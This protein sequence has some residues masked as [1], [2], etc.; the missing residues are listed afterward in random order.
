M[1]SPLLASLLAQTS[2][3][4][5]E[6]R[7][8]RVVDEQAA[9]WN[10]SFA[11]GVVW[12]P[13]AS[14]AMAAGG[15]ED[16]RSG[17]KASTSSLYP[18]GSATKLYTAIICLQLAERGLLDL[19]VPLARYVD[20]FLARTNGTSL[21][22]LW[23]GNAN[24]TNITTRMVIG[25]RSGVS[26]YDDAKVQAWSF[27]RANAGKDLTP[28][29]YLHA[30]D[31]TPKGFHFSPGTGGEYSSINFLLAG[32]TAAAV[33]N[34]TEWTDFDQ[35]SL[36]PEGLREEL[37]HFT[38]PLLGPCASYAGVVH[39]YAIRLTDV[40]ESAD[41]TTMAAEDITWA[42][43][44]NGWT[45]GN[46]AAA[47]HDVARVVHAAFGTAE[48][49]LLTSSSL[50][51]MFDFEPLTTGWSTGLMYGLGLMSGPAFPFEAPG[52]DPEL[53]T[54]VGHAGQDYGSGAPLHHYNAALD[55]SVVLATS[56]DPGINCSLT[57]IQTNTEAARVASCKVWEAVL[58]S[59]GK[60]QEAGLNCDSSPR[61]A[62]MHRRRGH[63]EAPFG[64]LVLNAAPL[65]LNATAS[66]GQKPI[67]CP[68]GGRCGG[69]SAALD[70][71]ECA[72][73]KALHARTGGTAWSVCAAHFT[74]P[75]SCEGVTCADDGGHVTHI[76]SLALPSVGMLGTLPEELTALTQLQLLNLSHN[77]LF[78]VAP[79]LPFGSYTAGCDLTDTLLACPL[80]AGAS[81]CGHPVCAPAGP[82]LSLLCGLGIA[83]LTLNAG[84][85]NASA[86]F[87][88]DLAV[89]SAELGQ[90]CVTE[91]QLNGTCHIP[92]QWN[93]SVE[94]RALLDDVERALTAA[95]PHAFY[96][97]AD[98]DT[99]TTCSNPPR[100]SQPCEVFISQATL[101]PLVPA[102]TNED[103]Q[104]F[105]SFIDSPASCISGGAKECRHT[106]SAATP[107]CSSAIPNPEP[108]SL[109]VR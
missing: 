60:V 89:V 86:E 80:P 99:N 69:A 25:M 88:T 109:E 41:W 10:T 20:P 105:L 37:K 79:T 71:A 44:L 4:E 18:L 28:Y 2:P 90:S 108:H 11:V 46:L 16:H 47:P 7:L 43:C 51:Q 95:N 78:G 82:K 40:Q 27:D 31:L 48:P 12:G 84:V 52:I 3:A 8:Q 91:L 34:A 68:T 58:V 23:H 38:F 85:A 63:F 30:D 70:P 45:F 35:R 106:W 24:I 98:M 93:T 62:A 14:T 56:S 107:K 36:L 49:R 74:D 83:A 15:I 81:S 13:N 33:S 104:A 87:Y 100:P 75:C 32:L 101:V 21:L 1:L 76:T 26:D 22:Q 66:D 65:G 96:C 57:D 9:Q 61:T 59:F 72:A 6:A 103:K 42:S 97:L 54:F 39:Q 29:D 102:C 67:H 77:Q 73:W 17:T 64:S 92:L 5:L 53:V 19:D 50:E 94:G 55:V